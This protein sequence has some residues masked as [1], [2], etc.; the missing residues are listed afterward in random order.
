MF[1]LTLIRSVGFILTRNLLILQNQN[2]KAIVPVKDH[3]LARVTYRGTSA[4]KKIKKKF[5]ESGLIERVK[6]TPFRQ[7]FEAEDLKFSGALY[8]SMML[9]KTICFKDSEVQFC[10][11][12]SYARFGLIE[13]ALITGLDFS[14][15][16]SDAEMKAHCTSDRI[17]DT[18]FNGASE[19]LILKQLEDSLD[20]ATDLN[21]IFKLG[22][23]CLVEGVLITHEPKSKITVSYL[24]MVEDLEFFN[25]YP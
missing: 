6:E 14:K 15:E 21:D 7:F 3:F 22:L 24:R 1:D 17:L 23:C 19:N 12:S 10:F 20:S 16:P 5:E 4:L 8:H 9:H 13:Y 25:R 2:G 18:H 11:G